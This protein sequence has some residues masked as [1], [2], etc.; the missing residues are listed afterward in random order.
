MIGS[1]LETW[2][3]IKH[4]HAFLYLPSFIEYTTCL[5][6]VIKVSLICFSSEKVQICN[7]ALCS[8]NTFLLVSFFIHRSL[9]RT[10]KLLQK[11]H[12]L[13]TFVSESMMKCH[14]LFLL[15]MDCTKSELLFANSM[16]VVNKVG[17]VSSYSYNAMEKLSFFW[18]SY[19]YWNG[20][21][22]SGHTYSVPVSNRQ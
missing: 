21:K 15:D 22:S 8:N 18:W 19:M 13:N 17:I 10:W 2:F 14:R 4:P 16:I 11:W 3:R 20:S 6:N 7:L 9:W 5:F 12:L 1:P